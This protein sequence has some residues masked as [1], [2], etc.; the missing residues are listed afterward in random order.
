MENCAAP[1]LEVDK[2]DIIRCE[3]CL[4]I[5]S[6]YPY[7]LNDILNIKKKC[8]CGN[9]KIFTLSEF[10]DVEKNINDKLCDVC[11]KKK[12]CYYCDSKNIF[13]CDECSKH[14]E[15]NTLKDCF[16][17]YSYCLIHNR[18]FEAFC[19][20]CQKN[21]CKDCKLSKEQQLHIDDI[22]QLKEYPMK[23]EINNII[24]IQVKKFE[25]FKALKGKLLDKLK[26]FDN[27][28][29]IQLEFLKQLHSNV[30]TLEENNLYNCFLQKNLYRYCNDIYKKNYTKIDLILNKGNSFLSLLE[31]HFLTVSEINTKGSIDHIELFKNEFYVSSMRNSSFLNFFHIQNNCLKKS[32]DMK[33]KI[34]YFTPLN[35]DDIIICYKNKKMKIVKI[36]L[37]ENDFQIIQNFDVDL[38]I[39][40]I[41]QFQNKTLITFSDISMNIWEKSENKYS[42]I[43]KI[44]FCKSNDS[45]GVLKI[46]ENKFVISSLESKSLNFWDTIN[47]EK[48]S[49]KNIE[50][51]NFK[52]N[53]CML[54]KDILCYGSK[55]QYGYYLINI[56]NYQFI[57]NIIGPQIIY[58]I[59]SLDNEKCL[60]SVLE[61][62]INVIKLYQL[63]NGNL[64][65]LAIHQPNTIALV[66]SFLDLRN[67][68]I[69]LKK[70]DDTIKIITS[71]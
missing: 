8:E 36:N 4:K 46:N 48:K 13:V 41:L 12:I 71:F 31:T 47:Y 16:K 58:S 21:I 57:K 43:K 50:T 25:D 39:Q 63:N 55:S 51:T 32:I 7:I 42:S 24:E 35:N 38:A 54:N 20:I 23:T 61:S 64:I 5:P 18:P 56:N 65:E 26:E 11:N 68:L 62:N 37:P 69:L 27:L 53:M 60:A 3:K 19:K 14:Y 66:T 34:S 44:E 29:S 9:E 59:I 45:Y 2:K 1:A 49:M 10:L 70:A 28:F 67:G 15:H 30:L 40:K 6:L 52:D 22:Y 33:E 17:L